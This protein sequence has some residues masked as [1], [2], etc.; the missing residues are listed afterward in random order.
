MEDLNYIQRF[1]EYLES[2]YSP[3]LRGIDSLEERPG[4][5]GVDRIAVVLE[6][7][8]D[9]DELEKAMEDAGYDTRRDEGDESLQI[10]EPEMID[11]N[12]HIPRYATL[13]NGQEEIVLEVN[14]E[15]GELKVPGSWDEQK[16]DV[17]VTYLDHQTF[18]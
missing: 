13:E 6:D 14:E 16:L 2:V 1:E 7:E 4:T 9:L 5:P 8:V 15:N 17:L 18:S 10:F 3:D 11:D 12:K